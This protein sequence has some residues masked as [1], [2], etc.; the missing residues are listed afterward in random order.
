MDKENR[1]TGKGI[2]ILIIGLAI[3]AMA[4]VGYLAYQDIRDHKEFEKQWELDNKVD[5]Q[6]INDS[7]YHV[8]L[9]DGSACFTIE[10]FQD[11]LSLTG[12]NLVMAILDRDTLTVMSTAPSSTWKHV[13]EFA[14]Y[15]FFDDTIP[16]RSKVDIKLN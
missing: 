7:T 16:D 11:S 14:Y 4:Y 2:V 5:I 1:K 10:K 6:R 15:D 9:G 13:Y 12:V 3:A 8:N